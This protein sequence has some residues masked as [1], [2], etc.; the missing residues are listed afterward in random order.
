MRDYSPVAD[1]VTQSL[2]LGI[3]GI[4]EKDAKGATAVAVELCCLFG[5]IKPGPNGRMRKKSEFN[6]KW[7]IMNGD[8][9]THKNTEAFAN[10]AADRTLSLEEKS[11][12]A[13]LILDVFD[14][15]LFAPGDWHAGMNMM[16]AIY[17]IYWHSLLKHMKKRLNIARLSKN[18][19]NCYYEAH[20]LLMFCNCEFTRYLW[21]LFVSD[22][23][24]KYEEKMSVRYAC[25][26]VA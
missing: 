21:H 1:L 12:F 14:K 11:K 7:M 24:E 5:M 18:I 26:T 16:Q 6:R 9:K 17:N 13:D 8:R 23:W 20:K 25:D 4:D 3:S 10:L 15:V 19:R 22:R 2:L